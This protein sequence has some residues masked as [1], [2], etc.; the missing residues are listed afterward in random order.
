MVREPFHVCTGE[1]IQTYEDLKRFASSTSDGAFHYH[2]NENKN[3]FVPWIENC[4]MNKELA[5]KISTAKTRSQFL[6]ALEEKKSN[7]FPEGH[8]LNHI[9]GL[10]AKKETEIKAPETPNTN[11]NN[12]T[13]NNEYNSNDSESSNTGEELKVE[14][15]PLKE[16]KIEEDN[17]EQKEKTIE[18]NIEKKKGFFGMMFSKKEKQIK[19]QVEVKKE[20]IKI[21]KPVVIED[22]HLK[23]L[24]EIEKGTKGKSIFSKFRFKK[25]VELTPHFVF[26]EFMRGVVFGFI[27]GLALAYMIYNLV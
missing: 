14:R 4:L 9:K 5:L 18:T 19:P 27:V 11:Y 13:N 23:K 25:E 16:F 17:T 24:K 7:I 20:P 2:V 8:P 10:F 3:D 12:S 26:R 21:E 1:D 22:S 6:E 15:P